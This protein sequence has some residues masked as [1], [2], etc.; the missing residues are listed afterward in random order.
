MNSPMVLRKF[1]N[2][3]AWFTA[4][5]VNI[6]RPQ[7]T[8][9]LKWPL[10]FHDTVRNLLC[11]LEKILHFTASFCLIT[12]HIIGKWL[13]K[14]CRVSDIR[15]LT[16]RWH[17]CPP[18]LSWYCLSLSFI[19][20]MSNLSLLLLPLHFYFFSTQSTHVAANVRSLHIIKTQYIYCQI[21]T[22]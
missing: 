13:T 2:L 7:I 1:C 21:I 6:R 18:I 8:R 4:L 9:T 22:I 14:T 11:Y 3:K 12:F 5:R 15:P 17:W 19:Q 20:N 10:L 16:D